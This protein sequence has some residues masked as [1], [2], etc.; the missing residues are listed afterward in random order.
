MTDHDASIGRLYAASPDDFV[1]QRD[2]LARSLRKDGDRQAADEVKKLRKPSVA[3]WTVN[4]LA[5]REKMRLR[6]L[7]TAGERLRAAHEEVLAGAA[8]NALE[9]ARDDERNAIGE[10]VA[11]A[12]ALL[13][14]SGRPPSEGVL[15]R[16]RET[17]HA[18]IVDEE[19]GERVRAGRLEK[20]ER[21]TGFGFT[22]LPA[23]IAKPRKPAAAR[24]R[25]GREAVKDD[26]A[27]AKRRR[28]EEAASQRRLRA[29]E[30]LRAAR[31]ALAEA[32]RALKS[33]RRDLERAERELENRRAA[34]KSAE[35][36]LA[37]ARSS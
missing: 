31:A 16:V 14:E 2:E 4:Q 18:A 30:G 1:K 3:A 27:P 28:A 9:K 21:A 20:E 35:R 19:I 13:E 29:Q 34:V 7:F 32:E 12:R 15:D 11:A 6:G 25:R 37:R 8:P 5:R 33:R 24:P 10:L 26:A 17:L 22:S 36:A 23:T